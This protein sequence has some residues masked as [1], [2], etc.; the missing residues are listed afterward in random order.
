MYDYAHP[1]SDALEGITHSICTL[2]FEDHRPL[3]D[4]C[5]A[6]LPLP[7]QPRQIEFARLNLTYTMMSKRRLLQ[8][9]NEK[10]VSGW[11]DPRMPTL[12]GLRRRG[13]TPEAIR[14]FAERIGVAKNDSTVDVGV[15]E[16][17]IREDLEKRATRALAVLRPLKVVID[18][19]PEGQVDWFEAP[20]HPDDATQGMRKIPFSK[21][22]YIEQDDFMEIPPKKWFR[23][24]PG[25]EIRLRYACLIRCTQVVKNDKGEVVEL[26]CTWDPA[27]R[28][29]DAPD[30]RRVKGTSHWVS[31]AHAVKATVRLYDR[32]FT[33]ES[34]AAGDAL[35]PASLEVL[36]G[37]YL[38]PSLAE[39]APG[40]RFQFERLGYFCVDTVDSK[41]G[42]PVFNRTVPLKDGWSKIA[43]TGR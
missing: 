42:T 37:A 15:L 13:Y 27:S 1:I 18:N 34:P 8:L 16:F 24:S 30:G 5:I 43:K 7:Y 31:A 26:H 4:W 23:L 9:V 36:D 12:S 40:A 32:L 14:A 10:L 28:G 3:Y 22:V 38:E 17:A 20:N 41:P 19:Y 11:N 29:G 35:N 21:V 33:T 6:N 25:S 39:A 2:E